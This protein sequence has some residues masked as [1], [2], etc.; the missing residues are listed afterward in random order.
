MPRTTVPMRFGNARLAVLFSF[1]LHGGLILAARYRF[2]YDTYNHMFFGDHYR[3]DWWSLWDARWYAG[4]F[5]N[6]YPP[7]VHQLIGALSHLIGLD[8]A[9]ALILWVVVTLL[10]LAVYSFA[11]VFV[12]KTSAGYAALGAAFLPSVYLTAHIFGQLPTLAATVTALFG[13]AVLNQYL[14][15]GDKFNGMLAVS[16]LSTVMALHH[17]TL[18]FLPWLVLAIVLQLW[19]TKQVDWRLLGARLLIF[20][21]FA[22]LA[23]LIVIWPFWEWGQAQ[24]LQTTIDHASRHN[25]FKDPMAPL[26]FFLPV[27]GPLMLIIPGV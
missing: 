21:V 7:L 11:G 17:A 9:F 12:G 2:S 23:I 26:M 6:S 5:V 3:M 27:Y 20:G 18:M 24:S 4:F 15:A 8:A 22:A 1:L 19:I 10:P 13:M 16:L 14:L 25:F